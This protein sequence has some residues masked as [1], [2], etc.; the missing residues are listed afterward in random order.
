MSRNHSRPV[1]E[2]PNPFGL[3]DSQC[4]I[5]LEA[6]SNVQLTEIMQTFGGG[7]GDSVKQLLLCFPVPGYNTFCRDFGTPNKY[8]GSDRRGMMEGIES[9]IAF[10]RLLKNLGTLGE[11]RLKVRFME[12][13]GCDV[14]PDGRWRRGDTAWYVWDS[15]DG[16]MPG[17][18]SAK[19]AITLEGKVTF[20]DNEGK[21]EESI[22]GYVSDD[23]LFKSWNEAAE[24]MA[25]V[26]TEHVKY[27]VEDATKEGW[28]FGTGSDP[29]VTKDGFYV[30]R[31]TF[32]G[33]NGVRVVEQTNRSAS[34]ARAFMLVK[35]QRIKNG[36]TEYQVEAGTTGTGTGTTNDPEAP[37]VGEAAIME[38]LDAGTTGK[39]HSHSIEVTDPTPVSTK[40]A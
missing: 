23:L 35:L 39:V 17:I 29:S 14:S 18:R 19:V 34:L 37:A 24:H 36:A 5:D 21:P 32:T 33:A 2:T 1:R 31:A 38:A 16:S 13:Y 9:T 15:E 27:T 28:V 6:M 22:P 30:L 4:H 40:P 3:Q 25:K 8:G 7:M 10:M 20:Q 26:M 12:V 11:E